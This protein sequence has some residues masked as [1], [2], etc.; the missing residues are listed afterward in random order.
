MKYFTNI[1]LSFV[2]CLFLNNNVIGKVN[3]NALPDKL[4]Q[5]ND[6]RIGPKYILGIQIGI[7]KVNI[8]DE[9]GFFKT[10]RIFN[11]YKPNFGIFLQNRINRRICINGILS[12]KNYGFEYEATYPDDS[13]S[14][15]KT[16]NHYLATQINI[17][18]FFSPRKARI[19]FFSGVEVLYL[20]DSGENYSA[21]ISSHLVRE[22]LE[23]ESMQD[24]IMNRCFISVITGLRSEFNFI[25]P[26]YFSIQADYSLLSP[27]QDRILKDGD[28]NPLP[29]P[30]EFINFSLNLNIPLHSFK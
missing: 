8:M 9:T 13:N 16:E 22:K 15:L 3:K 4:P 24:Y 27:T 2:F 30:F 19:S 20:F 26:F 6:E 14:N 17:H 29:Y 5:T 12:Y 23:F 10:N 21:T 1:F 7:T 18:Y 28:Y 25:I 11:N